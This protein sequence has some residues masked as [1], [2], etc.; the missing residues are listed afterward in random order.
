[1]EDYKEDI[2]AGNLLTHIWIKP[3]RTL[4]YIL[5]NCPD[6]Y[7]PILLGL[8]GIVRAIDRASIKD[9]GDTMSTSAIIISAIIGGGLF[10]WLTYYAYAWAMSV[11]GRWLKGSAPAASFRTVVAWALIPSI[12]SLL[13]LPPEVAIFGEDLFKSEPTNTSDFHDLTRAIFGVLELILST[14]TLV[15]L[16]KGI[17]LIQNFT[18]GRSIINLLLPGMLFIGIIV[19]AALIFKML[20]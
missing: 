11:T 20:G 10:G 7:V 12:F 14:W 3:K 2:H 15:I 5:Q 8:G 9:A 19:V 6:K 4:A 16:T 18:V 1:M 17:S 13:L